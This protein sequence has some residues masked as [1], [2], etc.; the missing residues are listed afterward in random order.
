MVSIIAVGNPGVGKS[1]ILNSLAE[2]LLFQS[3]TS[4]GKGLTYQLDERVNK[5]E[6]RF[7]DTPGLADRTLR[8]AA[9]EAITRA[10]RKGGDY[11]ILFFLRTQSGRA[12]G[13]EVTTMKL[14]LDSAPEIGDQYGIV[15]N[16]V[17][18]TLKKKLLGDEKN[19]R[20]FLTELLSSIDPKKH[21]NWSNINFLPTVD[22][23]EDEDNKLIPLEYL[24]TIDGKPFKTYVDKYIPS[25]RLTEGKAQEIAT[26]DFDKATEEIEKLKNEMNQNCLLYEQKQQE[27]KQE[28]DRKIQEMERNAQLAQKQAQQAQQQVEELHKRNQEMEQIAQA[29]REEAKRAQEQVQQLKEKKKEMEQSAAKDKKSEDQLTQIEKV[30]QTLQIKLAEQEVEA[31]QHRKM[32][33]QLLEAQQQ[34]QQDAQEKKCRAQQLQE[35]HEE[36]KGGFW[37]DVWKGVQG[38]AS[39]VAKVLGPQD[40]LARE[41]T[42]VLGIK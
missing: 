8:E 34:A 15:I 27:M 37:G 9:G 7:F 11:K 2:E 1:T 16:Q 13:E 14:V 18:P 42:Q 5:N 22:E 23:V 28:N 21:C 10:L 24:T 32:A 36:A 3:G 38:V 26:Q 40:I 4:F 19:A 39:L 35:N 33:Q 6:R 29:D 12:V 17:R 20:D 31:Q 30:L 25:V 41:I